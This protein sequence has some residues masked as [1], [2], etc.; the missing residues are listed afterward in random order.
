MSQTVKSIVDAYIW[1]T[2]LGR[3]PLSSV[4]SFVL[5]VHQVAN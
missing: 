5:G 2:G 3:S 4:V 1:G